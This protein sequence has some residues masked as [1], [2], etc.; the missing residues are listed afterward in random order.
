MAA[1]H[2]LIFGEMAGFK[3]VPFIVTHVKMKNFFHGA[4]KKKISANEKLPICMKTTDTCIK[5]LL[6]RS[7]DLVSWHN[8]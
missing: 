4:M 7:Q 5:L 6:Y 2:I 1:V 3:I 8:G